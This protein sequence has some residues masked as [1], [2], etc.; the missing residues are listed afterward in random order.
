MTVELT[1]DEWMRLLNCA[2][3]AP[4]SQVQPLIVKISDQILKQ[5]NSVGSEA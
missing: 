3:L 2:A 5:K 1:E 4:Y